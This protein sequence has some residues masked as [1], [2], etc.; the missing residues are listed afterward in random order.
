[1]KTMKKYFVFLSAALVSFALASCQKEV[2]APEEP[3]IEP[4]VEVTGVVPFDINAHIAETKTTLNTSTYEVAW[5]DSDVL[6]AVTTDAAWGDGTSSSDAS[7]DNIAT[8]SYDGAKFTTDKVIADGSHTFNFIYEGS[9]QKK[10]HRATGT[11]HQLYAT[12]TVDAE[13]PVQNLKANDALV[14]QITKTVPAS[15][16]DITMSHIYSLMKVTIKN[17][18]GS[19]VTATKFEIEI[20]GEDLAGIF[21]VAFDTPGVSLKSGGTDMITVN[22]TNGA[23]DN[24]GSID[25]YFVMAPV[26][27]FTGDVTFTV[28]TSDSKTYSK[29]NS[30]ADLTFAA[31]TYNTANFSLKAAPMKT[32]TRINSI[33]DLTTGDYVIVGEQSTTSYGIFPCVTP[34]NKGRIAYTKDYSSSGEV[35]ASITTNDASEVFTLTVSGS[36]PKTVTIYN[37]A[38]SKYLTASSSL[39]WASSSPTSFT[40]TAT[41]NQFCFA[42]A[43][44]YLGVNQ[45]ND[46]WRDYASSTLVQTNDLILYKLDNRTLSSIALSGT[47]PTAFYTGDTFS[48]E[49]L[50]VT[51]T[52]D[53]SSAS[54][55]TP[56][57]VSTPDLST[58]GVKNVTVSYTF[59]DVTKTANYDVT[60]TNLPA[61]TVTLADTST[62]LEE[63]SPGAGV[64]L[65]SREAVG[66]YTFTGWSETNVSV[67]TTTAPIIIPA[68]AYNPTSNVTLYPVYTK[69]TSSTGWTK[70]A[71]DAVSAGV[72]IIY[73]QSGYPFDGTITNGHGN[74]IATAITFAGN[75]ATSI[76][77]GALEITLAAVT[78]GFTMYAEGKGYLYATKAASGGLSW[79]N[80]EESYWEYASSNWKYNS[81]SAYLR[82]YDASSKG[83]RTYGSNLGNGTILLIK[84]ATIYTTVYNS[85]PLA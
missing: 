39:A 42:T 17:K 69:T 2:D 70:T 27:D 77:D 74:C 65:P 81:N 54:V 67:E 20:E 78:G 45:N 30:V 21:N 43:S 41:D 1:M 4:K 19:D 71:L 34:D 8:F 15:L 73:N 10:Y 58:P 32:Y 56:T 50:V 46:Y 83:I 47:Y 59:R 57:S 37:S 25:I 75:T 49:G 7:G 36:S 31:G 51:A 63:A 18:L 6:Y 66:Q 62:D 48:Y 79:H 64:V 80:S 22:I 24:N 5:Q 28:T 29:T 60:V 38:I 16:T 35:P 40:A 85:S 23:I 76:P 33:G 84:K 3:V 11:T 44:T 26:T 14:G 9:G 12:Q 53:D 72:Y 82:S 55:V 68:G 13:N 61:F 52:Y